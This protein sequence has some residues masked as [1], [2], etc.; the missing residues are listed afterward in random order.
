[1][2]TEHCRPIQSMSVKSDADELLRMTQAIYIRICQ[3]HTYAEN[4]H[5]PTVTIHLPYFQFLHDCVCT[6]AH[7]PKTTMPF[8]ELEHKYSFSTPAHSALF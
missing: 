2:I 7:P 3:R 4:I 5:L 6:I 1:M 8:T